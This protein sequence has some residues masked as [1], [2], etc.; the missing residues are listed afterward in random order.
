MTRIREEEE[1]SH[2]WW[3]LTTQRATCSLSSGVW[4][5]ILCA[6]WAYRRPWIMIRIRDHRVRGNAKNLRITGSGPVR[7]PH[8]VVHIIRDVGLRQTAQTCTVW[9]QWSV[10]CFV[11]VAPRA[12]PTTAADNDGFQCLLCA[13]KY[14]YIHHVCL[15]PGTCA[16]VSCSVVCSNRA[17]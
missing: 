4:G 5:K 9:W 13:N 12:F 1:V 6:E 11:C 3:L 7:S 14:T 15:V 17:Y 8:K 16:R 10:S 2:D